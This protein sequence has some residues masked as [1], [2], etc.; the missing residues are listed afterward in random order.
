MNIYLVD[1]LES[2]GYDQYD[3]FVTIAEN[4][5]EARQTHPNPEYYKYKNGFWTFQY[6]NKKDREP[7]INNSSWINS[8]RIDKLKVTLL[9][10]ADK[11]QKKG[12]V[13]SSFNAG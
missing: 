7:E 1:R 11:K 6:K 5:D 4:E 9:G 2:I 12:V 3:S 10:T 8:N 13:I